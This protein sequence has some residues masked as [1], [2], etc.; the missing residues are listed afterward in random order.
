VCS[1]DLV[2]VL[3]IYPQLRFNAPESYMYIHETIDSVSGV[4]LFYN[5]NSSYRP[6]YS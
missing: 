2:R 6:G 3:W 4:L 1:S 5:L